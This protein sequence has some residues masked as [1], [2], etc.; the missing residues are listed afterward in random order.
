MDVEAPAPVA[1]S[2]AAAPAAPAAK[3]MRSSIRQYGL[4]PLVILF[5]LNAVDEFDRAVLT[6]ALDDIR[7]YFALS[8]F[9]GNALLEA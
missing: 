4:R 3:A 2:D 9:T 1:G 5:L 8:D 7:E 6:I